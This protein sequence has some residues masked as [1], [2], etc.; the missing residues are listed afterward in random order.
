MY[1]QMFNIQLLQYA[2]G[3][4]LENKLLENQVELTHKD[5]EAAKERENYLLKGM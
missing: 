1:F 5:I 4:L 2:T 3:V